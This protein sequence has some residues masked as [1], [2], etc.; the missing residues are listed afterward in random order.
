MPSG[1]SGFASAASRLPKAGRVVCAEIA[2][3]TRANAWEW[4][5]ALGGCWCDGDVVTP[6]PPM[7][8]P[9]PTRRSCCKKT[10]Q[11]E[12]IFFPARCGCHFQSSRS[13]LPTPCP[14]SPIR[15]GVLLPRPAAHPVS[16]M[17]LF[18][19]PIC[20]PLGVPSHAQRLTKKSL[21]DGF[22]QVSDDLLFS[23]RI[24]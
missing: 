20:I 1:A 9:S 7:C 18:V 5:A 15:R 24:D 11:A 8:Y 6:A 19:P 4:R 3:Q 14:A 13:V 16:S 10:F 23:Y 2:Q 17:F 22:Y 12:T 21:L